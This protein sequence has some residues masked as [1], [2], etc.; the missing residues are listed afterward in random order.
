MA[1]MSNYAKQAAADYFFR[2]GVLAPTRPTSHRM[3]LW[4][5]ITDSDAGTGTEFTSGT[6][7]GYVRATITWGTIALPSGIMAT[8]ITASFPAA[9]GNWPAATHYGI[10]DQVGNLLQSLTV[11]TVPRTVL[12]GG[13]GEITAGALTLTLS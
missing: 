2:P 3:S 8:S 4:S 5:A 12:T 11:L 7:P 6:A 10:H 1:E 13:H 9:T